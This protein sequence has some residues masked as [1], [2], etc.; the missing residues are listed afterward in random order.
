MADDADMSDGPIQG[1]VDA[2]WE[3]AKQAL[4]NPSLMPIVQFLE[5]TTQRVGICHY[6]M[7]EITPGHLFC[8]VD[9]V[10]PD[11]SCSVRWEHRQ[12][13]LKASGL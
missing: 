12:K 11:E 9:E 3:R 10:E 1:T 7:S 13:Q 5:D 4:K 6:C 8:P 2:G